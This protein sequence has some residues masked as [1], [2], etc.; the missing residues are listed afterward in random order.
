MRMIE[1][2]CAEDGIDVL[3]YGFG[4]S[5][6][7]RRFG[8]ESWEE[9][10]VLVFAPTFRGVRINATGT[11]VSA[12][13]RLRK[14]VAAKTGIA[15]MAQ[16]PLA[17]PSGSADPSRSASPSPQGRFSSSGLYLRAFRSYPRCCVNRLHAN[18]I[19]RNCGQ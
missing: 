3:D 18:G 16:T 8:S 14:A 15:R 6:Y 5:E 2:L 12:R 11:A 19:W 7:K 13:R 1:E 4:E 10:D 9:E 17:P